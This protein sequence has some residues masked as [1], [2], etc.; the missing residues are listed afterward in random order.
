MNDPHHSDMEVSTHRLFHTV[1]C[2]ENSRLEGPKNSFIQSVATRHEQSIRWDCL[3]EVV[4]VAQI[5]AV[6]HFNLYQ[7][8]VIELVGRCERAGN[9]TPL[10]AKVH[11]YTYYCHQQF[12]AILHSTL[13]PIH[14]RMLCLDNAVVQRS[15]P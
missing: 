11:M 8:D 14:R 12:I 9:N 2:S 3:K 15:S 1:S 5:Y 6:P 4:L 7:S 10:N 13:I